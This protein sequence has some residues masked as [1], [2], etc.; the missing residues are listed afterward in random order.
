MLT[1]QPVPP[2]PADFGRRVHRRL[3]GALLV[4]HFVE[5]AVSVWP[6]VVLALLPAVVDL[7]AQTL[8]GKRREEKP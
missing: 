7:L 8:G 5:L 4:S 6:A 3:N 1:E 2:A